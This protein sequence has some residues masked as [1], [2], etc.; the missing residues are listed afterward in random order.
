MS[1]SVIGGQAP[2]KPSLLQLSKNPFCVAAVINT[3]I[4]YILSGVSVVRQVRFVFY[5]IY[6]FFI[7]VVLG[8]HCGI[9]KSSYNAP[10]MSYLNSSPQS[11]SFIF[12]P[13]TPGIVSTSLIFPFTYM[14][15][16]NLHHI[17]PPTSFLW[18]LPTPTGSNP[19]DRIC[20]ELARFVTEDGESKIHFSLIT[21]QHNH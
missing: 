1:H 7:I 9:Y 10:N 4:G 11:F 21:L 12:P 3:I 8:V 14:G 15:S 20:S 17:H 6:L 2:W 19:S 16:Q 13:T 18:I 5:F